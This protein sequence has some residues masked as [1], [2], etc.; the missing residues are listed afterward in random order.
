MTKLEY[1]NADLEDAALD[2]GIYRSGRAASMAGLSV[3]TLR[4]WER[5]YG[6]STPD[7]SANGQRLYS[8]EQVHRLKLIRNLVHQG[9]QIGALA[10]LTSEDLLALG[11][12]PVSFSEARERPIRVMVVGE[13]LEQRM[14]S[15]GTANRALE[16][17]HA[18]RNL[19]ASSDALGKVDADVLVIEVPEL[20]DGA[21]PLIT[22]LRQITGIAAVIVVY[23]FCGAST[24][25]TLRKQGYLV[26]RMPADP[27]EFAVLCD[28]ALAAQPPLPSKR[29]AAGSSTMPALP[30]R[31]DDE[32]LTTL[33][34]VAN[35]IGCDC[36]RHLAEIL[37]MLNSFER[38]S[39]QCGSRNPDDAHVHAP[40]T[41]A[42]AQAR[43]LLESAMERLALAEGLPLPAGL[44][45]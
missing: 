25:R 41:L 15:G 23:R 32:A 43:G 9:H 28:A 3:E 16:V 5:R 22:V 12:P 19:D 37:L 8:R 33:V 18:A 42:V 29:A 30:R 6:I 11:D 7:R 39:E 1:V 45:R 20:E 21:V 4:V 2:I 10:N 17:V 35:N 44:R 40:L 27:T 31:L 13:N 26:V 38:Y 14:T 24:L 34:S 36:P